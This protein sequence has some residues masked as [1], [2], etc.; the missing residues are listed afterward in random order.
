MRERITKVK[1][2]AENV[3]LNMQKYIFL[4]ILICHGIVAMAQVAVRDEP[5]HHNV[6]ENEYV[7][8]LDV[9]FEPGDTTLFHIHST[10]SVFISFT[11]TITG[12]QLAGQ[13]PARSTTAVPGRL[14][15]DSLGTPRIHRVWNEDSTWFHVMD[16][17]LTAGKP[18]HMEPVLQNP[19]L[20]LI[21]NRFMANGYS[22]QLKQGDNL[23]LPVSGAGYLIVSIGDADINVNTLQSRL[24]KPGHSIWI[25]AGQVSSIVS[26]APGSF[27]ILQLK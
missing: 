14:S 23:Q 9:H 24:L 4:I 13:P 18:R 8:V 21:F 10:P 2:A 7:R 22:A 3:S 20:K 26:N 16:I 25:E 19:L 17:E 5:R 6:F 27:A 15:Y 11:K 1:R 12:S